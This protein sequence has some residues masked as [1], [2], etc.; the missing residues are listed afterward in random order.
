MI[1]G[2]VPCDRGQGDGLGRL[3]DV[4]LHVQQLKDALRAGQR[5]LEL[6]EKLR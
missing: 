4:R 3:H 6:P 5:R 2:H 1:V